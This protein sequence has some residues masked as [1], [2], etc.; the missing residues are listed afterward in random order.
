VT[1]RASSDREA[2]ERVCAD[3]L[4]LLAQIESHSEK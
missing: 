1:L 4:A 3:L 2:L